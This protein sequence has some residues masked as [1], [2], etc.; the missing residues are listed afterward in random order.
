M[1]PPANKSVDINDNISP[2]QPTDYHQPSSDYPQPTSYN[3][4][5]Q[6]QVGSISMHS[7]NNYFNDNTKPVSIVVSRRPQKCFS[8]RFVHS[9]EERLS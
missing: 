6:P 8:D 5:D 3:P 2:Q 1:Q 9:L 7:S 4:W